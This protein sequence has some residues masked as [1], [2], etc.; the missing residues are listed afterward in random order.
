MR[1]DCIH[2]GRAADFVSENIRNRESKCR[3]LDC[4]VDRVIVLISGSVNKKS[5]TTA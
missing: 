1:T 5:V 3:Q 2:N 4:S